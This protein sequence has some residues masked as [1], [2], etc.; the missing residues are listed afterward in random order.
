MLLSIQWLQVV[1]YVLIGVLF[2][3]YTILDGFDLGIASLMPFL[4]RNDAERR[5]LF[6]VIG[7]LWDGNEVWLLVG[8]GALF[9]AFPHAYASVF[10]GFY[11]AFMM[12]LIF[13]ILRAVALEFWH[14][15]ETRRP[16][17]HGT[18]VIASLAA[19]TLLGVA[20][21]NI[22]AGVP[23]NERGDYAAGFGLLLRPLPLAIGLLALTAVL[24]HGSA[25]AAYKTVGLMRQRAFRC[26]RAMGA[27]FICFFAGAGLLAA[28]EMP[29]AFRRLP[30][31]LTAAAAILAWIGCQWALK[32]E[33][34]R[35][36]LVFS[37]LQLIALWGMTAAFQ[38]PLLVRSNPVL[39]RSLTI[40]NSSSS[41]L[42]L[43]VMLVI[44]L[45]GL[46]LVAAYTVY[47]Y[48]VFKG[49]EESAATRD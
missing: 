43:T 42:T 26:C 3:V 19:V 6:R 34:E 20:L 2:C 41:Q 29:L 24:I 5:A 44:G 17:W 33:K 47:A 31:W 48:R 7:P 15:D 25:F 14:H 4:A 46:P 49:R 16:L 1:W 40:F 18:L 8:A 27:P 22:V 23:L 12:L 9:A 45:I 32:K 37:S 30:I 28:L 10:S 36:A 35:Q 21:G 38:F 39:S 11:L 13:L